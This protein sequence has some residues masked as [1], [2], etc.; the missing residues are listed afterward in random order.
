M[1]CQTLNEI[2]TL[3]RLMHCLIK[4][5][6]YRWYDMHGEPRDGIWRALDRSAPWTWA[7]ACGRSATPLDERGL[8]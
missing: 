5:D 8:G 4:P 7:E 1:V 6:Q 3:R 2:R